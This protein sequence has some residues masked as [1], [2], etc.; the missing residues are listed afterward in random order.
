MATS[1]RWFVTGAMAL[2]REYIQSAPTGHVQRPDTDARDGD[3][4]NE[5]RCLTLYPNDR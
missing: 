5:G 3:G 1:G 2:R 4:A